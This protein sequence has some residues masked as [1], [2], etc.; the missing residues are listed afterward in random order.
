MILNASHEI[1]LSG[2]PS[3]VL[4]TYV[5][6]KKGT[7]AIVSWIV[8]Y[9]PSK[10]HRVKSMPLKELAGLAAS[11]AGVVKELPDVIHFHFRETIAARKRLS[12]YFRGNVDKSQQ[13]VDTVNHEHFTTR[14]VSVTSSLVL[15]IYD[16]LTQIYA[17]LCSCCE[18][19]SSKCPPSKTPQ[20]QGIVSETHRNHYEHLPLEEA[21]END[22]SKSE[23]E[24]SQPCSE[25]QTGTPPSCPRLGDDAGFTDDELGNAIELATIVQVT[26]FPLAGSLY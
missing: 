17:R 9:R 25:C 3:D 18:K 7:R 4:E 20:L 16:S 21:S 26:F 10:Y 14:Y 6:Y 5:R 8:Q 12:K 1:T 24:I 22:Q 11:L 13:A 23:S 15:L 2:L 19:P